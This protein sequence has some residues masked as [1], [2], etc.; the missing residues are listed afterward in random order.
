MQVCLLAI[1]GFDFPDKVAMTILPSRE[2]LSTL[3]NVSS[4]VLQVL[5]YV[6]LRRLVGHVRWVNRFYCEQRRPVLLLGEE[7][8]ERK[9]STNDH[10]G[11][12]VEDTTLP[13]AIVLKHR[14]S[15][16]SLRVYRDVLDV[17]KVGTNFFVLLSQLFDAFFSV[18]VEK[19]GELGDIHDVLFLPVKFFDEVCILNGLYSFLN[20]SGLLVNLALSLGEG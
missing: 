15:V 17:L 6:L 12:S 3:K 10:L 16:A 2:L 1:S 13:V 14:L 11:D 7:S 19:L 18:F 4:Q 8:F 20:H 5:F 9:K